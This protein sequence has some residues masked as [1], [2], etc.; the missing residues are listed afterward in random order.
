MFLGGFKKVV[1]RGLGVIQI[2]KLELTTMSNFL[3]SSM[4]LC[5]FICALLSVSS[6]VIKTCNSSFRCS[7]FGLP[8]FC[9]S[10]KKKR[11]AKIYQIIF[12]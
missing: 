5:I 10:Y 11:K 8:R 7:Q 9:S 4:A 3:T 1:H 6:T 12:Y 2:N